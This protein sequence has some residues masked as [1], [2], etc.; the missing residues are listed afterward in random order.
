MREETVR[1]YKFAWE[2]VGKYLGAALLVAACGVSALAAQQAQTKPQP[3]AMRSS[4]AAVIV[5]AKVT[6]LES[7]D[8][9]GPI[10]KATE[11]LRNDFEKV[12]GAKPRIVTS[13][14]DA[15]PVTIM[16][17][18]AAKLP[19]DVRPAGLSDPES[20]SISVTKTNAG[21]KTPTEVVLLTGAD[22]RGT[23][24]A[25]YQFSQEY[26]GIDPMYYWTDQAPARRTSV[27]VPATLA[28]TY[29]APL[30]KYRGFFLNDEDMLTGWA[31]GEKTDGSGIAL[32]VMNKVYETILR[33]KGNMGVPGTWIFPDDP[34]V[35]LVGQRG[36][37]MT[38]HHAIPLGVNV[39]RWPADQPYNYTT[40]P[41]ILERAWKNAVAEYDPNE[42]ILWAVGLRGLSDSSYATMDPSVV[43]NDKALGALISKAIA[44]QMS[45]V[46][47]VHPDAKFVTDLWQEGARLVQNG[48][49]TIPPGVTEVW[50]DTGY[51]DP[52]DKGQVAAGQGVYYHVA[53][54]NGSANQL[55]EMVPVDRIDA[56]L[57]RYI[58]VGATEYM[59][60]N[61]SDIRAVTMTTKA[62]M[63]VAWGGLPAGATDDQYYRDW[64]TKEFGEKSA[65]AVAK[66]YEEYFKAPAI[67][68][69]NPMR[70]YGDQLYH[71]ETRQLLM[72]YMVSPPYYSIPSQ[73]PKWTAARIMGMTG[74]GYGPPPGFAP[75]PP[76]ATG[77]TA[78][79]APA[80]GAT[81][82]PAPGAGFFN[83]TPADYMKRII[84]LEIKQCG[85]A[86]PRWDKVWKDAV[87]AQA[88]VAPSRVPFYRYEMLTMIAINKDSNHI[89]YLISNAI[90]DAQNGQ[91]AK[92]KQEA[93]DALKAF[94]EIHQ[95][96][97]GAEY[98]QWKNWFRGDW[99]TGVDQTRDL[100]QTFVKYLDDPMI[101]LPPPVNAGG[102]EGYY[103]I[104]HYEGNRTVDVK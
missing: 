45:I 61:T 15:G 11:D 103:H 28:K 20:F 30:F 51:G 24:Y 94:D 9:A 56:E 33:L 101:T 39:A 38:Q 1:R 59:L 77:G 27:A 31:P 63:D 7:A 66:V 96:E 91:T 85:D 4:G 100:V 37:I 6:I 54:L 21:G 16:I 57:G 5:T 84:P 89:L 87:A 88:L 67:S 53:M 79:G 102:W 64:A 86:Q 76:T 25:I 19:D 44:E 36:L 34:Q 47:A 104:L 2:L 40:H 23:M 3:T 14:A 83:L 43:G 62:V 68:P 97:A 71:S 70:M 69:I 32:S 12:L 18:E 90:Q 26:L 65:A 35:K 92:A 13:A 98:G 75:P 8:T 29:P 49:L 80:A 48:D 46:R 50:A 99:L 55:S 10:Q 95:L 78:T 52:Q 73:S 60:L 93:E 74:P 41:E 58:K 22:M 17:G 81:A 72:D 82:T 42:E